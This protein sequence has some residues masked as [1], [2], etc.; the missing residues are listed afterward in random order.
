MN[1]LIQITY[2]AN[3]NMLRQR[4]SFRLK[5]AKPEVLAYE[6]WKQFRINYAKSELLNV[7]ANELDISEQVKKLEKE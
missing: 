3:G 4:G 2:M 5:G 6:W 1:I 7:F